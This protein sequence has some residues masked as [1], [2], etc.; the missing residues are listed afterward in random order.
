MSL[1]E[2][3]LFSVALQGVP[4]SWEK[5]Q[6]ALGRVCLVLSRDEETPIFLIR[7]E[8]LTAGLKKK[9][10]SVFFCLQAAAS[11]HPRPPASRMNGSLPAFPR[12]E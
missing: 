1:R 12:M 4:E 10:A 6:N 9:E 3:A 11:I 5:T 2:I 7:F 8:G